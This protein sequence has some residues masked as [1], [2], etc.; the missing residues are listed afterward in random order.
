MGTRKAGVAKRAAA[1]GDAG[2]G[3]ADEAYRGGYS[4]A[5]GEEGRDRR[6]AVEISEV[7]RCPSD[8]LITGAYL[9]YPRTG[10]VDGY[11]FEVNGWV[12]SE[13]PVAELE[14]VHEQSVV[15]CCELTVFA[16]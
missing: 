15:A 6:M 2:D 9:D 3:V 7:T 10:P 8:D 11:A 5:L 1:A 4:D 12:V 13:A 14:F 16:A